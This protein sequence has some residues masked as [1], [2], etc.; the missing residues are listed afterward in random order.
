[1]ENMINKHLKQVY[2]GF[3]RPTTFIMFCNFENIKIDIEKYKKAGWVIIDELINN[4]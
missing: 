4:K 1:M 2:V 3:S